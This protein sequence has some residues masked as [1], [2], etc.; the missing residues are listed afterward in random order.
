[1][2]TNMRQLQ[3]PSDSRPVRVLGAIL[4]ERRDV[5]EA[6]RF[7]NPTLQSCM[8]LDWTLH[9]SPVHSMPTGVEPTLAGKVTTECHF[10]RSRVYNHT[11]QQ[12][13]AF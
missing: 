5:I 12:S 6:N 4:D 1:M 3:Q 7:H 8:S 2:I 13:K 11:G 10:A 9:S